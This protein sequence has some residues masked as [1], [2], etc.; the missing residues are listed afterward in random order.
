MCE[1]TWA[2]AEKSL[3]FT[4]K[5]HLELKLPLVGSDLYHYKT[6]FLSQSYYRILIMSRPL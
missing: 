5:A 3:H 2:E 4:V 1:K 6:N